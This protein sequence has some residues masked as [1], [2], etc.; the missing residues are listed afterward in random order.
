MVVDLATEDVRPLAATGVHVFA[1]IY[2]PTG[3]QLAVRSGRRTLL[4]TPNGLVSPLPAPLRTGWIPLGWSSDGR[5]LLLQ[6][7]QR[8]GGT[9]VLARCSDVAT[10]DVSSG[11]VARAGCALDATWEPM[12]DRIVL[13]VNR[14]RSEQVGGPRRLVTV[15]A[16]GAQRRVVAGDA[17]AGSFPAGE[18]IGL[19]LPSHVL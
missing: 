13:G 11:A 2:R 7:A 18:G 5:Y 14:F 1:P 15:S 10:Y 4:V 3:D 9:D 12:T 6:A 19:E 8:G 17:A 16:S